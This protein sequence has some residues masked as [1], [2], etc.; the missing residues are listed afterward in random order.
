MGK[1]RK[2]RSEREREEIS[3]FSPPSQPRPRKREKKKNSSTTTET[4]TQTKK[5]KTK[6]KTPGPLRQ[7]PHLGRPRLGLGGETLTNRP[8]DEHRDVD[9]PADR[10]TPRVPQVSWGRGGAPDRQGSGVRGRRDGGDGGAGGGGRG[11]QG[12]AGARL[13]GF[14]STVEFFFTNT[15]K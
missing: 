5:T 15:K 7:P 11:G 8:G 14:G 12:C 4:P 1:R 9:Q 3:F 13:K 10:K 6:T 2:E